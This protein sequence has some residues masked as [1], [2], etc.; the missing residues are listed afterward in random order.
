M[1][2][3]RLATLVREVGLEDAGEIVALASSTQLA[4]LF[5]E[6]VWETEAG[7]EQE[8][9]GA[10]RFA[11]WLEVIAEAG[12]EAMAERLVSL[13]F[14]MVLL[15]YSKLVV[16]LNDDRLE[17]L[18]SDLAEQDADELD[19]RLDGFSQE[20]WHE[21]R[22]LARSERHWDTAWS[23]LVSLDTRHT[24]ELRAILEHCERVSH[25]VLDAH[26]DIEELF[27][28]LDELEEAARGERDERRAREGY[29][30]LQ[31]ARAFLRLATAGINYGSARDPISQ[32]HFRE[33]DD[34]PGGG[35]G[36]AQALP[37]SKGAWVDRLQPA[38]DGL[39]VDAGDSWLFAAALAEL[40]T[41]APELASLRKSEVAYLVN[42][43][44]AASQSLEP[45]LR[46]VEAL[47][48]ALQ[49]LSQG[50]L[51]HSS[52][53]GGAEL[54]AMASAVT[55]VAEVPADR[56]FRTGWHHGAGLDGW[57][58]DWRNRIIASLGPLARGDG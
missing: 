18:V 41:E 50:L 34:A 11:L 19:K 8:E 22:V 9:L 33:L 29:V 32:A 23:S 58:Q 12:D 7:R 43:L 16:V 52:G 45:K 1:A 20:Q 57:A 6:D 38:G 14:E 31:D 24:T 35:R 53:S 27:D 30:A 49:V 10:E 36:R 17:R 46:P 54:T 4:R 39:A 55:V 28:A 3:S 48:L 25:E 21:F 56:L 26:E 15:G 13:P 44:V 5:D 42:V 47:E 2:P 51:E 40:T 37:E